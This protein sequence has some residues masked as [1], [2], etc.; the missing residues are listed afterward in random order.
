MMIRLVEVTVNPQSKN[1]Y[2]L[3][4]PLRVPERIRGQ[5][6]QQVVSK[7]NVFLQPHSNYQYSKQSLH[8]AQSDRIF[9]ITQPNSFA[10]V[11]NTSFSTYKQMQNH[12]QPQHTKTNFLK[13]HIKNK[14]FIDS[15]SRRGI[16]RLLFKSNIFTMFS[17]SGKYSLSI[18]DAD[19][20]VYVRTRAGPK[21]V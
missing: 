6:Q 20:S 1:T 11:A 14:R 15:K 18:S 17:F 4:C 3:R 10:F 2:C 8:F 21:F 5:R 16:T 19:S 9:A 13:N 7:I 12:T